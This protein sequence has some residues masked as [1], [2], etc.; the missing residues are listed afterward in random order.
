MTI[1]VN[2]VH[3]RLNA[4]EVSGIVVPRTPDDVR[5]AV[6]DSRE[7]GIALAVSGA[8]HAM[9]GQQFRQAARLLDMREMKRALHL[10]HQR[11][12]LRIEAGAQWPEV[13]QATAA[14]R[15]GIR[16]K[17]TGADALT[18]GGSIACNAHGR[19]LLMGPL[20]DDVESLTLVDALG[21]VRTCSRDED[22]ELFSLVVGGYGLFGV[23]IDATLRLTPRLKLRRLVDVIDVDDALHAVGRR[24]AEGCLYGD[25]QYA[26]DATDDSFLRRGV[27]ACYKP[28]P[29]DTAVDDEAADLSRESWLGLLKLAHTDKRRAFQAY[30][31]H[32]LSTHGRIYWSDTMQL[33]TYIPSYAEFLADALGRDAPESLMITELYV[34]PDRIIDFM[35]AARQVLRSTGVEDIYGTIR[36]IRKDTTTYLP[37]A[38]ED[39]ACVIF[40]LRTPHSAKGIERSSVAARGLI[41]AAADL[42]GSFYLTYHRWAT[43]EQ[44]LRCHPRFPAFLA[45][46]KRYD[47]GEVFQS[48]WYAHHLELLQ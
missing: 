24:V 3:S 28:V 42:G 11:G 21:D 14:S 41:D 43:R 13:V 33:G 22:A 4:T 2:D 23:V 25:F 26:I 47:P 46:K 20:V 31:E 34:P 38:R 27:F 7:R 44:V 1:Q 12:L 9:G 8:R 36:S 39:F 15:W 17:Q 48:D 16:Q 10:D 30:A 6:E 37:W 19:G 45:L 40:N 32:Y 35:A 29:D 5:R 18:L